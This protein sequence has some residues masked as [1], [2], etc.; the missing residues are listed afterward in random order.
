[1]IRAIQRWAARHT[2]ERRYSPV[3]IVFHWV[4]AAL[5]VGGAALSLVAVAWQGLPAMLSS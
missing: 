4:M 2:A 5:A 3:G 1:M